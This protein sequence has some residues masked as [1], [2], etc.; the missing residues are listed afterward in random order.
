MADYDA[1]VEK[2]EAQNKPILDAFRE[3]LAAKG[4]SK[5]TIR[6][7]VDNIDFFADFLTYYEPVEAL[8][9]ADEGDIGSFCG[10]WFPRKAMWAS[11]SS[12]RSN[13]ASFRKFAAFMVESAR[14]DKAKAQDIR[15]LL[16][17]NKDEFIEVAAGYDDV[18]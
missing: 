1:E 6:N 12:A 17:E 13:M 11:A 16:K 15:E 2:I 9:D 3:W 8:V 18:W 4:L 10:N 7:H 5:K 14:W